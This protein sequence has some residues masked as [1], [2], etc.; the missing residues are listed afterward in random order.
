MHHFPYA[1]ATY[2]D[3]ILYT[4]YAI[5]QKSWHSFH[6]IYQ[7]IFRSYSTNVGWLSQEICDSNLCGHNKIKA[8]AVLMYYCENSFAC[9]HSEVFVA[10][11]HHYTNNKKSQSSALI[12]TCSKSLCDGTG[13]NKGI[14]G[15]TFIWI[16]TETF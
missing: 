9:V 5:S 7:Q 6:L 4:M 3:T 15:E 1:I 2:K 16:K 8:S 12:I 13:S 11:L 10:F 14:W